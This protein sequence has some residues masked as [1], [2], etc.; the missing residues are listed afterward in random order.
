MAEVKGKSTSVK[1]RHFPIV[2]GSV[3]VTVV[4]AVFLTV[5]LY[6]NKEAVL[7]SN[8][9]ETD[10]VRVTEQLKAMGASFEIADSGR[11]ILVP[12]GTMHETRLA[13][14]SSNMELTGPTGFELFDQAEFGLTDFAQKINYRRALEGELARTIIS[15]SNITS[16]RVH[17]SLPEKRS[18]VS[19]NERPE[20]SV[21][22]VIRE[23]FSVSPSQVNGIQGLIASAVEGLDAGNVNVIDS[24]GNSIIPSDD[25]LN[26][27]TSDQLSTKKTV[28][29]YISE[30]VLRLLAPSF[31]EANVSVVADVELNFDKQKSIVK[32]MISAD[33]SASG[34]LLRKRESAQNSGKNKDQA[35]AD[36][37][38]FE[39][40][41][42]FGSE[43]TEKEVASGSIERLALGV[44]IRA[45]ITESTLEK[46]RLLVAASAGLKPGRGDLL[47]VQLLPAFLVN[48]EIASSASINKGPVAF[49]EAY[50][51]DVQRTDK[52]A[53][54]YSLL[55]FSVN[56]YTAAGLVCGL[57]LIAFLLLRANT[58][59]S[60]RLSS[61]EKT[62]LLVELNSWIKAEPVSG[63]SKRSV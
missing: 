3:V 61:N 40:E 8:L 55:G 24:Q 6:R 51:S 63:H 13:L 26:L 62:D 36:D 30:K 27:N 57:L 54:A 9:E 19:G 25:I 60:P 38:S 22:L 16:A 44:V 29:D 46:I 47:Q 12:E 39:A 42:S 23:G 48:T 34:Y 17:I 21:A 43:V 15:F 10:A 52:K 14:L 59:S 37:K 50:S 4:I 41:F 49:E 35:S 33:D 20:A 2:V 11:T 56:P 58:N 1:N 7:F 31:G 18:F 53:A 45:D 32:D 5:Y 28:E